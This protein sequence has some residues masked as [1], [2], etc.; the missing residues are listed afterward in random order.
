[1]DWYNLTLEFCEAVKK[2][3]EKSLWFIGTDVHDTLL[4][5]KN[6]RSSATEFW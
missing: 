4:S 2:R 1:M 5:E 3:R 6:S